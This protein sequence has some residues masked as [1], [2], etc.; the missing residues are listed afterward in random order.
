[1][2]QDVR[3][4]V[5]NGAVS[6]SWSNVFGPVAE[7]IFSAYYISRYVNRVAQA[8]KKEYPLPMTA[9]CW[10][11]KGGEPGTYP[12]GGPVSRMYEVWQY[13]APLH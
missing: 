4:S 13:G 9:N 7:E 5:E 2:V 6:G 3:E 1:M 8:G 11:D 10:L 12:S